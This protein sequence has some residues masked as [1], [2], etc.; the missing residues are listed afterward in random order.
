MKNIV[1]VCLILLLF[2]LCFVKADDGPFITELGALQPMQESHVRMESEDV[3]FTYAADGSINGNATF[4]FVNTTNEKITLDTIFPLEGNAGNDEAV[5]YA[6]DV[7]VKVGG[8]I[9]KTETKKGFYP[10]RDEKGNL[11]T[12]PE[13]MGMVFPLS[14]APQGKL[15]VEVSFVPETNLWLFPTFSYLI[16]S[17]AG[18]SG[19]IGQANFSV[20]YPMELQSGWVTMEFFDGSGMKPFP[21]E[22]KIN[23][24]K[25]T[26][27]MENLE[28]GEGSRMISVEILPLSMAKDIIAAQNVVKAAADDPDAYWHLADVYKN[29]VD[30]GYGPAASSYRRPDFTRVA[31]WEFVEKA[32]ALDD[33]GFGSKYSNFSVTGMY[34]RLRLYSNDW[35]VVCKP[36]DCT[37][38][39]NA[40]KYQ[41][42]LNK[43]QNLDG[44]SYIG[45]NGDDLLIAHA[46]DLDSSWRILRRDLFPVASSTYEA[47]Y[48]GS[49]EKT[50]AADFSAPTNPSQQSAAAAKETSQPERFPDYV[51]YLLGGLAGAIT[52][53]V[54][55]VLAR[56]VLKS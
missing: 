6:K 37:G 26:F 51:L 13:V 5:A 43:M 16:G 29:I 30:H 47:A 42:T 20:I 50:S 24:K 31:Y 56:R 35:D 40:E 41:D 9:M 45:Q 34:N 14:F 52:G 15:Q 48:G 54:V 1:T 46:K 36:Y 12:S 25:V 10:E 32:L 55:T 28:P 39:V 4:N 11:T 38:L 3:V 22:A 49:A 21:T 2:P 33:V 23:G 8:R 53:S 7:T 44:T 17:G 27:S 19:P 18:W